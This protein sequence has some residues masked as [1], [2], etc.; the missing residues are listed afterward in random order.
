MMFNAYIT[1][2]MSSQDTQSMQNL[3]TSIMALQR[4]DKSLTDNL[5]L[6]VTPSIFIELKRI[7]PS[8]G[9]R[10]W[11]GFLLREALICVARYCYG[12]S[13]VCL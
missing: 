12:M 1:H 10:N 3:S 8:T 2:A 4:H 13:S 9:I 6:M 11:S 7:I 5:L